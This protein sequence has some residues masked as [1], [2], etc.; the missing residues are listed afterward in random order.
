M[1]RVYS[2][3][4]CH[5]YHTTI[6]SWHHSTAG[7]EHACAYDMFYY[8]GK[9]NRA[10]NSSGTALLTTFTRYFFALVREKMTEFDWSSFLVGRSIASTRQGRMG[11]FKQFAREHIF[12]KRPRKLCSPRN[13]Q[14]KG[15]HNRR[16]TH[17]EAR[18]QNR[19]VDIQSNRPTPSGGMPRST[20]ALAS[21][22][23][24]RSWA[25]RATPQ[26]QT[27]RTSIVDDYK[28]RTLCTYSL[29]PRQE[30]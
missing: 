4:L 24:F 16:C 3:T 25:T 14:K 7:P 18:R 19:C 28:R 22:S 27:L 23:V 6:T 26:Y 10:Q 21:S 20:R 2:V 29:Y 15:R 9:E 5:Q 30:S 12:F 8:S 13:Q 1:R 11:P 17:A